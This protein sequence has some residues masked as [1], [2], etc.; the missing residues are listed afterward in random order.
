[1]SLLHLQKKISI[2]QTEKRDEWEMSKK[3]K[4]RKVYVQSF[5]GTVTKCME[6]YQKSL[7][8]DKP[9]HFI[10]QVC[11]NDL[12]GSYLG[13]DCNLCFLQMPYFGR[14]VTISA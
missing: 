11:T 5:P 10:L 6:D 12:T 2:S 8:R 4:H 9:D 7:M 1:M 13:F 14:Q 3:L